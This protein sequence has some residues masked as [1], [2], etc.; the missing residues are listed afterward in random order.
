MKRLIAALLALSLVLFA[1]GSDDADDADDAPS[2]EGDG[3]SAYNTLNV[4]EDH[5]TIQDAL[6][7]AEEGDLILVAPGV[8]TPDDVITVETPNVTIRGL[9]RN[10]TIID[11]EFERE[12]GIIVFSDGV[13]V[14][15]MTV[16]NH[17]KNGVF[18]TGTYSANPDENLI[19]T[20]YRASYM[21]VYNNGLYGLYA[22]NATQ[23]QFDN[24]YGSGHP[25]SAFYIGQC[26]PCDALLTNLVSER[27]MLGYS[28]TNSTGVTIVNSTF[29]ENRAGIVPN[30][31]YS[32]EL[33]PN[34]GTTMIGNVVSNNNAADAPSNDGFAIAFGNGIVLGGVS[35]N[36]V[37][38]NLIINHANTGVVVIDQPESTDPNGDEKSFLPE[39]NVVRANTLSDNALGDLVYV[40]LN[41]DSTLHGNCFEDN[42]FTS[43]SPESIEEVMACGA[44]DT[45]L[46]GLLAPLAG[47]EAAPP[48]V[49][50]QQVAEPGPQENMPDAATA[51]P[52]SMDNVP[53]T[54]DL[55]AITTPTA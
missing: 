30:S 17:V 33:Y 3:D 24:S 26:N 21:T 1:C 14:E 11:G 23:G 43:S 8:Y 52:S 18:F 29:N 4:P 55:D 38:R 15:N 5:E 45:T 42:E 49:D 31:L 12:N 6:D 41:Y 9:D 37:E 47:I 51:A 34:E 13:A 48:D 53:M 40:V 7:A 20:G 28:G 36:L 19:L 22:F 39:N 2:A 10:E 27:N 32:E 44:E 54:V 25:D 50:W 16:R 46:E 35:N